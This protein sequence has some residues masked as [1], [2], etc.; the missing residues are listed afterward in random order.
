MNQPQGATVSGELRLVAHA[1]QSY[2]VH[3][4]LRAPPLTPGG[5]PQVRSSEGRDRRMAAA[6]E[7]EWCGLCDEQLFQGLPTRVAALAFVTGASPSPLYCVYLQE[8]KGKFDLKEP[9]YR[10]Q[11]QWMMQMA[12]AAPTSAADAG[13]AAAAE[14]PAVEAAAAVMGVPQ[15]LMDTN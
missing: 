2:D 1:R 7:S 6:V 3:V 8:S 14:S 4:T 11:M 5:P 13:A 9:Y 12:A 10:Q 15:H